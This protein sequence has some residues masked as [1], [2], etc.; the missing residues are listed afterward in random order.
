[1]GEDPPSFIETDTED[2]EDDESDAD[3]NGN[4]D[5]FVVSDKS[6]SD[7]EDNGEPPVSKATKRTPVKKRPTTSTRK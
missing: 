2:E 1:M 7:D 3:E 5:G 6:E 4:L